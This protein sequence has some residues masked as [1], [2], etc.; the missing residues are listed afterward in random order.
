M[1][2]EEGNFVYILHGNNEEKETLAFGYPIS[3]KVECE[4][5]F[6]QWKNAIQLC[7]DYCT[8]KK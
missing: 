1:I 4:R 5:Y 3:F 2:V 8:T 6:T 7:C